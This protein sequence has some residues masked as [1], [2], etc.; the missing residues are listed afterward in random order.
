M[1]VS[2]VLDCLRLWK[3]RGPALVVAA[4]PGLLLSG[5][6]LYLPIVSYLGRLQSYLVAPS[7]RSASLAL[8]AAGLSLVCWCLFQSMAA[9]AIARNLGGRAVTGVFP[10]RR[11]EL[12]MFGTALRYLVLITAWGLM[13]FGGYAFLGM[14]A[15]VYVPGLAL[16]VLLAGVA[17]LAAR[18]LLLAPAV[19]VSERGVVLRRAW[20]LTFD[21]QLP[22]LAIWA[23]LYLLPMLGLELLGETLLG[24]LHPLQPA[25]QASTDIVPA[26]VQALRAWLPGLVICFSIGNGMGLILATTAGMVLHHSLVEAKPATAEPSHAH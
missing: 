17:Y 18:A 4:M 19:I 25:M 14:F 20:Q 23:L 11:A 16:V 26:E 24:L 12:R 22:V 2:T 7:P 6:A 15:R 3:T 10:L 13:A 1:I 5:L 9:M 8:G 21:C